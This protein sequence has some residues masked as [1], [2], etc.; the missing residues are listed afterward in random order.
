MMTDQKPTILWDWG[1]AY[2]LFASLHVL[3]HPDKFGLRG[4]WAAG[5]RSRLTASQRTILEDAQGL[6]F[7]SPLMWVSNLP[8]PKDAASAL[9]TLSKITPAER[10]PMLAFHVDESPEM[11]EMLKQVSN[12]RAW[13]ETDLARLHLHYE[14][15]GKIPHS[16]RLI[17]TL[18]WWSRPEEFGEHYLA[19]LQAYVAVF[20]A[21]EEKRIRPYLQQALIGAQTLATQLDFSELFIELSQGVMI[22]AL[23]QADEVKFVPSY[24]ITPLVMYN[25][26]TKNQWVVLYGARPADV[27]LVPGEVVPDAMLRA[28]KA[29]S[30]PTRLLILRYLSDTPQTPSQLARKLRLRAPTVIHHLNAL[31]LAGLVYVSMNVEDEKRYTVRETAVKDAFDAL[32]KFIL[33]KGDNKA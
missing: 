17:T 29:L 3:H 10:L 28:L 25:R 27:A 24:W 22:A 8:E 26:N 13:D 33:A 31:R 12:R 21:E 9:W 6:F 19:A 23:E 15:T 7:S 30:D 5:V 14:Q 18:N 2:D 20:F 32:R 11:L 1:T 16:N 4:S